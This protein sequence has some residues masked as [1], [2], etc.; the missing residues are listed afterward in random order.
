NWKKRQIRRQD[1]HKPPVFKDFFV[2]QRRNSTK[3]SSCL[4][5]SQEEWLGDGLRPV[6]VKGGTLPSLRRNFAW[7]SFGNIVQSGCNWALILVIAKFGTPWMVGQYA[8]GQ[9]VTGPIIV[10]AQLQLRYLL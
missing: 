4:A 7:T 2:Q 8:I 1:R 10:F 3:M 6:G 5:S 9:A